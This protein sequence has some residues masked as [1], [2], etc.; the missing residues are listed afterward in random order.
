MLLL[1]HVAVVVVI[2]RRRVGRPTLDV[3]VDVVGDRVNTVLTLKKSVI[4]WCVSCIMH[5]KN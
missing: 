4:S 2:G 3:V 5:L 1:L